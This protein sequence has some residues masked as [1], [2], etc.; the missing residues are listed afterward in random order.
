ML[1]TVGDKADQTELQL[2][3]DGARAAVSVLDPARRTRDIWI[4]D[5][6]RN[7]LRTRFTFDAGEDWTSAWSPDGRTLIFSAGRPAGL[8]LYQK[9]ADGSGTESKLVEGS[10]GP[11]KYVK[12]WS[13]DG[14]FVLFNS[15]SA[16]SATGNDLW[17]LP[18]SEDRKPRALLQTRFVEVESRF[19][20]DSRWVAYQ[21]NESGSNEIYV[22]PF[23]TNGGKWLVSTA[24]GVQ[25][26]WRRD[27][28][29]IFYLAGNTIMA[30]AVDGT[31][32]GFQVGAVRPLF[33]VRRRT[34]GY[35]GFGPGMVY[36]VT[37]DGQ[38]FLVNVVA[39][40]QE[41]PPPITVITN[42]TATLR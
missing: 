36:D 28:R 17:V 29:E 34:A 22:M 40:E 7:G 18:L 26:R 6:A 1:G 33:D 8:D 12:S 39:E 16:G 10:G 38:R 11:N 5:L 27:G 24:G 3:P 30:A 19:S 14:R 25:P 41:S 35:L 21:S 32:T 23:A 31:G 4:Y 13:A 15:G 2:S 37:A 42:W 9:N 20:P